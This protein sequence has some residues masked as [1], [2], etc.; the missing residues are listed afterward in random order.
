MEGEQTVLVDVPTSE[1]KFRLSSDF[2]CLISFLS[3]LSCQELLQA[4]RLFFREKSHH[5]LCPSRGP[6]EG[7][8]HKSRFV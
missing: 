7:T 2:F 4:L 6:S 8:M 3:V 5:D 1:K